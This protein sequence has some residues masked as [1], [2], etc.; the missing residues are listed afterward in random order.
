MKKDGDKRQT[1]AERDP[2]AIQE[3]EGLRAGWLEDQLR[4][5]RHRLARHRVRINRK[6]SYVP[7][8]L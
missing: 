2:E 6:H 1:R 4:L 7:C 3:L 8:L 5:A